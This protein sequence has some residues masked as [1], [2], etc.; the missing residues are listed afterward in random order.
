VAC[1]VPH[2]RRR[3][4][5]IHEHKPPGQRVKRVT[6]ELNLAK[7]SEHELDVGRPRLD[8]PPAR[9]RKR[10]LV[11]LDADHRT[12]GAHQFG[13]KQTDIAR[14][15][16]DIEDPH[17]GLDS[18]TRQQTACELC[19]HVGLPAQPLVLVLAGGAQRIPRVSRHRHAARF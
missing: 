15:T 18:C 16:A 3:I 11:T 4:A 6:G 2:R 12:I 9:G 19:I 5:L 10:L 14:P 8:C 17:P 7:V 13:Q 1:R